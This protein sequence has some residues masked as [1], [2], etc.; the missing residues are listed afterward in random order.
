M[1]IIS[2]LVLCVLIFLSLVMWLGFSEYPS[3]SAVLKVGFNKLGFSIHTYREEIVAVGT[4]FI[5][6]FTIIL[7]FAT[8]FLYLATRNLVEG[9]DKKDERQLRAY[10]AILSG[11][12]APATVNGGP[13]YRIIVEFKN[14][15]QTPGYQFSTWIMPPEIRAVDAIPFGAPLPKEQ[16]TGSSIIGPGANANQVRFGIWSQT[17]ID[18]IRNGT[19]ALFVWGGADYT[20]IFGHDRYFIYRIAVSGMEDSGNSWALK[21]HKMGY[22]AN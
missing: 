5:A 13:G 12:I 19:K 21:P 1:K 3:F 10:V 16:R 15:G 14:S 11:G 8:G 20:D 2:G 17:E 18:E 22:D 6:A 9:A 4:L 7:A